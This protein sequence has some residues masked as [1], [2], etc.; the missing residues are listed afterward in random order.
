MTNRRS[1]FCAEI[2]GT[3]IHGW[4]ECEIHSGGTFGSIRHSSKVRRPYISC[5]MK[6][7]R[8]AQAPANAVDAVGDDP[9]ECPQHTLWTHRAPTP[10]LSLIVRVA[11]CCSPAGLSRA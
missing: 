8:V 3:V 6:R 10:G 4:R 7:R 11:A 1:D 5:P 2:T 9:R